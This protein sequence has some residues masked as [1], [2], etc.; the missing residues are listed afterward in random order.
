M[1]AHIAAGTVVTRVSRDA[2]A[3]RG[4]LIVPPTLASLIVTA[5]PRC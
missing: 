4:R 2:D 1:R 3:T 5:G